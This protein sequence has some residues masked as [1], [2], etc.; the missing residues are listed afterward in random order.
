MKNY[1]KSFNLR[2][3]QKLDYD[4]RGYREGYISGTGKGSDI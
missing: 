2:N 1:F 4:K 3:I